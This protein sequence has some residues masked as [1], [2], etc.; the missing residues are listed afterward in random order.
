MIKG[1]R[2][3][4]DESKRRANDLSQDLND[5]RRERDSLKLEKNDNFITYQKEMEELKNKNREV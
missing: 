1:L 2:R 3:E 4:L 5:M